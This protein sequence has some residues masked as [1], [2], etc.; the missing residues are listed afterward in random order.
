MCNIY[1]IQNKESISNLYRKK[2][3][4]HINRKSLV[5]EATLGLFASSELF[6]ELSSQICTR[7]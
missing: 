3:F 2:N 1:C 6:S 5:R 7:S 4:Y